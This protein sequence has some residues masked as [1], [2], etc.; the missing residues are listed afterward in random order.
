M[1]D[2]TKEVLHNPAV[3]ERAAGNLAENAPAKLIGKIPALAAGKWKVRIVTQYASG[4]GLTKEPRIIED[5][6]ELTVG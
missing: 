3:S 2:D 5:R 6:R 4:G 1:F